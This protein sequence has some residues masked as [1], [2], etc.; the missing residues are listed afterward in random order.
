MSKLK[1]ELI[2]ET[3]GK[4]IISFDNLDNYWVIIVDNKLFAPTHDTS[5]FDSR[6]KAWKCWS[7]QIAWTIKYKYKR[8]I[9]RQAGYTDSWNYP[10]KYPM[11][12]RSV[13][14]F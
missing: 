1:E 2:K 8:D 3:I 6:E 5:F 12:K 13:G 4:D 11:T 14:S 9:A 7:Q 10:H